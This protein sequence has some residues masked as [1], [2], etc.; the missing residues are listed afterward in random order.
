MKIFKLSRLSYSL[1][2]CDIQHNGKTY[3]YINEQKYL[4]R[5]GDNGRL[6]CN[7]CLGNLTTK[8]GT[9]Y[10]CAILNLWGN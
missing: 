4:I 7:K 1:A 5:K 2:L 9:T 10:E 8:L 3:Q 6:F